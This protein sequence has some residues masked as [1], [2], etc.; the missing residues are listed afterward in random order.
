MIYKTV[1]HIEP[2]QNGRQFPDEIFKCIFLNENVQISIKIS[3]KFFP[4]GP[5]NNILALV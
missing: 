2:R 4:K 3:L 5:I 1:K